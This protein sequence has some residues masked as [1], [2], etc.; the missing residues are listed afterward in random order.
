MKMFFELPPLSSFLIFC[1]LPAALLGLALLLFAASRRPGSALLPRVASRLL[2]G[3]CAASLVFFAGETYYRFFHDTTDSFG[4]NLATRRWVQEH[5]T[6]NSSGW[7]DDTTYSYA[8]APGKVRVSFIG[9]SFTVGHG[10]AD[11]SRRFANLIRKSEPGWE[12][13]VLAR[14]GW[15]TEAEWTML[16]RLLPTGY[17]SHVAVL[18][19]CLND[20][21]DLVPEWNAIRNSI[22]SRKPGSFALRWLCGNSYFFNIWYHRLNVMS[23]PGLADYYCFVE[24][25]YK[26]GLAETQKERLRRFAGFLRYHGIQPVVVTFPFLHALGKDYRYQPVHKELSMFWEDEQV[27]NLD[28]YEVYKGIPPDRLVVNSFDAHPNEYAHSLAAGA[29][30][31]FI[32]PYMRTARKKP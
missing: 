12:V 10:I 14:G 20:I 29:I 23:D 21:S 18:V 19:Y 9:D 32:S 25:A 16:S 28:L 26:S 24:G 13:H 8:V 2:L 31:E 1:A 11:V 3:L 17:R 22:Y 30:R 5:Y 27:P 7:R 15:D 4:L 6:F